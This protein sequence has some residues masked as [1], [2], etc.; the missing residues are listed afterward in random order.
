MSGFA[1]QTFIDN[2]VTLGNALAFDVFPHSISQELKGVLN[3]GATSATPLQDFNLRWKIFGDRV[4]PAPIELGVDLFVL[5]PTTSA[6]PGIAV[7]PYARGVSDATFDISDSLAIILKGVV[8]IS[9]G[10]LVSIRPG[11]NV[12]GERSAQRQSWHWR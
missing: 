9:K 11:Q 5:P 6:E 3:Q 1:Q 10:V 12:A 2:M 7:S 8:D 4:I